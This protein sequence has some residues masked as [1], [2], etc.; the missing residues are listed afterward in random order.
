[1]TQLGR[2]YPKAGANVD[3]RLVRDD[4]PNQRSIDATLNDYEIL[5]E[6]RV[7]PLSGLPVSPGRG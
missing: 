6:V 2:V 1:M 3:G 7:V 4:I 5:S